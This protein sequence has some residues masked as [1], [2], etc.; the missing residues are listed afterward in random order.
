MSNVLIVTVT[1]VEAKT[2][3]EL[4][5]KV[6]GTPWER[7]SI[8]RKIYYS[9]GV[10]G[11]SNLFMVQSEMGTAGPGAALLTVHKAIQAISPDAVIMIG[12]A[13][14]VNPLKQQ[15]G[16]ILVSRQ[17]QCYELQKVKSKKRIVR[18]DRVTASINLLDK[19]RSGDYDWPGAQVHFGVI[20]SGEKLIDD[21]SFRDELITIEPEAIG[22][23]MEG[24]GLYAA[25][26][27]AK[28]DWI[29]AKAICDWA[30]GS[31]SSE[32]QIIAAQNA[33]NFVLHVISHVGLNPTHDSLHPTAS[34]EIIQPQTIDSGKILLIDDDPSVCRDLEKRIKSEFKHCEITT[35]TN[36]N[37]AIVLISSFSP[38]LV[39][40][41]LEMPDNRGIP[42]VAKGLSLLS[43]IKSINRELPII[44]LTAFDETLLVIEAMR[45]GASYY[46]VKNDPKI[47][48]SLMR[49]VRNELMLSQSIHAHE[50]TTRLISYKLENSRSLLN[51]CKSKIA[52]LENSLV[53]ENN[54]QKRLGLE[55]DI[56]QLK[57][58]IQFY[59]QEVHDLELELKGSDTHWMPDLRGSEA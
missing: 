52:S 57:K 56:V 25:A 51:I 7:K 55:Q 43:E 45:L 9:L 19:F 31:K 41:D 1:K 22:G 54:S 37:Q 47:T 21:K 58:D 33:T 8:G 28:V 30:D 11:D 5:P 14:G 23:E 20:L 18:G 26:S 42:T 48:T 46:L 16:D 32:F 40:L 53:F 59:E 29:L 4:F 6:T 50:K 35:T 24:A 36:P 2:V 12:L 49:V 38:D 10:I 13:F 44:V 34:S 3:L 27:E 15:M 17:I 39:L